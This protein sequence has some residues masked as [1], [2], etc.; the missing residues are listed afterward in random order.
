[1]RTVIQGAQPSIT[2][3]SSGS[4]AVL[5][6]E[7]SS[8]LVGDVVHTA[9]H[10]YSVTTVTTL[11]DTT[12]IGSVTTA[13]SSVEIFDSSGET[14]ELKVNGVHKMYITPGGNDDVKSFKADVGDSIEVR[15]VSADASVGEITINFFG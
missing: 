8:G 11:A 1:M 2:E 4:W 12:L 6:Q 14:L 9:R 7:A 13:I 3:I 5:T 10:D 15:A